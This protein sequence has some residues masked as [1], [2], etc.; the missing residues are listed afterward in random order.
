MDTQTTF[1]WG[2]KASR[3]TKVVDTRGKFVKAPVHQVFVA[4]M[5]CRYQ[6]NKADLEQLRLMVKEEATR[7]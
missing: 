3:V 4:A 5:T 2:R 7:G 1:K 6:F